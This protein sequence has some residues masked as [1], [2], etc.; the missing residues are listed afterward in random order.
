MDK[1]EILFDGIPA[2]IS[3]Y[4][5]EF[6]FINPM[7]SKNHFNTG[8]SFEHTL[9]W[10]APNKARFQHANRIDTL[11]K[12]EYEYTILING[13]RFFQGIAKVQL[14]SFRQLKV[15]VISYGIAFAQALES[16]MLDELDLQE[17]TIYS[18]SDATVGEKLE[19]WENHVMSVMNSDPKQGSHKFPSI[20]TR[21]YQGDND[22]SN[23]Y[24]DI[25]QNIVNPFAEG[26]WQKNWRVP[27][28]AGESTKFDQWPVTV[29]PCPRLA[30]LIDKICDRFGITKKVGEMFTE[31]EYLQAFVFAGVV[32]DEVQRYTTS[33]GSYYN[34][35]HGSTIKLKNHVPKCS[36]LEPFNFLFET[37][38]ATFFKSKGELT[39]VTVKELMN[40][41]PIIM[42]SSSLE[43][44][45]ETQ[46][47]E[48]AL[49]VV[50]EDA[51]KN[52]WHS[53]L[54][55]INAVV[56]TDDLIDTDNQWD[57][58]NEDLAESK[59]QYVLKHQVMKST[60]F[61]IEGYAGSDVHAN[62]ETWSWY[63]NGEYSPRHMYFNG[64]SS[65]SED[66]QYRNEKLY[67]GLYRG[68]FTGFQWKFLNGVDPAVPNYVDQF[69][70]YSHDHSLWHP[71]STSVPFV[72]NF[73]KSFYLGMPNGTWQNWLK[74]YFLNGEMYDTLSIDV[75]MPVHQLINFCKFQDVKHILQ[76]KSGSIR[77][78]HEKISGRITERGIEGLSFSYRVPKDV[79]SKGD[80]SDDFSTDYYN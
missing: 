61:I 25:N 39:V 67:V 50:Y 40:K 56:S 54:P 49:S 42:K 13:S 30:Y 69:W 75:S 71:D 29:A 59:N 3:G 6:E 21:G 18:E 48:N 15:S 14:S 41:K 32:M 1:V 8:Y 64:I 27:Y 55:Y 36:T 72:H 80:F 16:I 65:V 10:S 45:I 33:S 7:F 47:Y 46:D 37:Y 26:S 43:P 34:N 68:K 35:I 24:H 79:L 63:G 9:P 58:I 53:F 62:G 60:F 70:S 17:F 73:G 22:S 20:Q 23:I 11:R 2:D 44:S 12:T 19:K 78:I 31:S 66:S 38:G 51:V 77:C 4:E 74:Y 76:Y 28:T 57:G 52:K 5:M